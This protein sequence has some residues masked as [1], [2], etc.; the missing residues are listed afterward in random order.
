M[1]HTH[2]TQYNRHTWKVNSEDGCVMGFLGRF[3]RF[4]D[5]IQIIHKMSPNLLGMCVLEQLSLCLL[6]LFYDLLGYPWHSQRL[7][8]GQVMKIRSQFSK[9][10]S[11]T[12]INKNSPV[13]EYL[14]LPCS[15]PWPWG[16]QIQSAPSCI[17]GMSQSVAGHSRTKT[18]SALTSL[19]ICP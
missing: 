11:M 13:R 3:V 5:R 14:S 8:E 16:Q 12:M 7:E 10:P 17:G 15:G 1:L 6:S 19:F 2:I 18:T 4:E 9:L